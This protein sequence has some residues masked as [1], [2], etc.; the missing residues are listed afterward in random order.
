MMINDLSVKAQKLPDDDG[1]L[2]LQP[3]VDQSR[4]S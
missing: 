2:R 1:F 3:T 4:L